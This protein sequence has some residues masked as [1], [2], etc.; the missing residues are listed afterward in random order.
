MFVNLHGREIAVASEVGR[1]Y[2]YY[3]AEEAHF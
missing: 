1:H 2:G 3:H